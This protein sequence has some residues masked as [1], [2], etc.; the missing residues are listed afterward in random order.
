MIEQRLRM[1]QLSI[2]ILG[3]A[4]L[5]AELVLKQHW[6][7]PWQIFPFVLC[8]LAIIVSFVCIFKHGYVVFL[9]L[10]LVMIMVVLGAI[11]GIAK[12]LQANFSTVLRL[13]IADISSIEVLGEALRGF[14][15]VL[16]PGGMIIGAILAA[17]ATYG[18]SLIGK[19]REKR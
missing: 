13:G 9:M 12:H 7:Q 6:R 14:A 5:M 2:S 15:P 11:I 4:G 10:R 18:Y 3:F 16:A 17:S 8:G 1:I 19:R